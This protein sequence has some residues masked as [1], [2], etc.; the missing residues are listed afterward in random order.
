MDAWLAGHR[1]GHIAQPTE[2]MRCCKP[3]W[4]TRGAQKHGHGG[5]ISGCVGVMSLRPSGGACQP[6]TCRNCPSIASQWTRRSSSTAAANSSHEKRAVGVAPER[7]W[8]RGIRT[9]AMAP[10]ERRCARDI[11]EPACSSSTP[12]TRTGN[13]THLIPL[14]CFLCP[15]LTD[16][17]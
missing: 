2:E 8:G 9:T 10:S 13:D 6:A 11:S 16:R 12:Q 1:D 3:A 5:N 15:K 14:D 17:D 7:H 4:S